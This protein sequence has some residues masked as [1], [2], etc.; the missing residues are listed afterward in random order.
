MR[1]ILIP[2]VVVCAACAQR[3]PAP[4]RPGAGMMS[5]QWTGRLRG[6]LSAPATARW[7]AADTLLEIIA[8]RGDTAVG[9]TLIA[10]DSARA[11]IYVVNETQ[12]FAPGRPQ[13]AV[14]LRLLGEMSLLG[15]EAIAGQVHVTQSGGPMVS[16]ALDVRLRPVSGADT[17]QMKGSFERIPV[18]AAAG[19]CGR[20]NHPGAG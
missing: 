13:A 15:F 11:E 17:L 20:A 19:V 6:S 16:G 10:R 2:A 8:V 3:S 1:L 14:A 18:G 12:N 4:A 7:C 9:L 5:V